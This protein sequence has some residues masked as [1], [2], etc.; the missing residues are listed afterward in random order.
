MNRGEVVESAKKQNECEAWLKKEEKLGGSRSAAR[1]IYL[2]TVNGEGIKLQTEKMNV[3]QNVNQNLSHGEHG[4]CYQPGKA[5]IGSVDAR[6]QTVVKR[7][8]GAEV[9]VPLPP[10]EPFVPPV[11]RIWQT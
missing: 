11:S 4:D 2:E 7:G 6:E 5:E 3:Q 9:S 1:Y 8:K 10:E